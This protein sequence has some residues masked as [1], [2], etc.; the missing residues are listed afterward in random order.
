MCTVLKSAKEVQESILPWLSLY[1]YMNLT[2]GNLAF[3]KKTRRGPIVYEYSDITNTKFSRGS[4]DAVT[5]LSVIEHGVNLDAYFSE[6]SRIIRAGGILITSTDYYETPID[7][8]GQEAFG[9][10][11]HIFTK[12]E[13]AHGLEVAARYGFSLM[14]PINLS[15]PEKVVHWKEYDLRYTFVIFSLQKVC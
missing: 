2:A 13:I 5:C 11:I 9:V 8:K 1:G 15:S 4:L 10:P 12:D 3:D 7:T 14:S 6:M